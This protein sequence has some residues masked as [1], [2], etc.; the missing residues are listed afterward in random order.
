[1]ATV[2]IRKQGGAAIIT[3]PA[4]LLAGLGVSVGE[5][6]EVE[7]EAGALVARPARRVGRQRFSV[8]QLTQGVTPAL[9]RRMA[10]ETAQF[11]EGAAVG[12]EL[13]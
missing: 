13:P 7:L 12:L 6:L 9:A 2:N 1:M 4:E 5:A 10:R 3:I 8:A 11:R